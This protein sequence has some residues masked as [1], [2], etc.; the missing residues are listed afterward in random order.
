MNIAKNTKCNKIYINCNKIYNTAFIKHSIFAL[1]LERMKQILL[2]GAT[3]ILI[4]LFSMFYIKYTN[5]PT[6]IGGIIINVFNLQLLTYLIVKNF[7][8]K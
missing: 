6:I 1:N 7:L 4:G 3:L 2:I 8:K 5:N